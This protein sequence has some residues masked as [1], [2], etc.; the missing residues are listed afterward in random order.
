MKLSERIKLIKYP[1]LF[2]G[3]VI[4]AIGGYA[5]Y[6]YVG[7]ITGNCAITSNPINSI[8]YGAL[9][10]FTLFYKEAKKPNSTST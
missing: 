3:T 8:L 2:L 9:V 7:C 10:G 5:Y 1:R 4:G 6:H